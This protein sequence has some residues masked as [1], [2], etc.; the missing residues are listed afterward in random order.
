MTHIR[1]PDPDEDAHQLV[2]CEPMAAT[3]GTSLA[4]TPAVL[5]VLTPLFRHI[6]AGAC[7]W[8]CGASVWQV[9]GTWRRRHLLSVSSSPLLSCALPSFRLAQTVVTTFTAAGSDPCYVLDVASR[10]VALLC[11]CGCCRRQF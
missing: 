3:D 4:F 8:A 1:F 11:C 9:C 6:S 5:A 10:R 2:D 7:R